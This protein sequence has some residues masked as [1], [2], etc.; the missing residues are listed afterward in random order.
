MRGSRILPTIIISTYFSVCA[1]ATASEAEQ[2]VRVSTI[3]LSMVSL[4]QGD[5]ICRSY[6][7]D[8]NSFEEHSCTNWG[9]PESVYILPHLFGPENLPAYYDHTGNPRAYNDIG[10][11]VY[12]ILTDHNYAVQIEG[13]ESEL[14]P[15]DKLEEF[16]ASYKL[17]KGVHAVRAKDHNGTR[18]E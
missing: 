12:F 9:Q 3:P 10:H 15:D 6:N 7:P 18:P 8:L 16:M 14:G 11:G 5:G 2:S 17:P 1:L 4:N 13:K